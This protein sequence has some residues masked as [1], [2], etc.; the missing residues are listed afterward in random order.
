V[1][2][3]LYKCVGLAVVLFFILTTGQ[4]RAELPPEAQEAEHEGFIA[5]KNQEWVV[6]IKDFQKARETAPNAPELLKNLGLAESKIPGRELRAIAWF[7]AYLAANTNA[8]DTAAL[9]DEINP[10]FPD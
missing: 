6:A 4:L 3:K 7:G 5:A 10:Y 1:K 2:L 9:K 8:P